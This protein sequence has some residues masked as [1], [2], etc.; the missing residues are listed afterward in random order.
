MHVIDSYF[1]PCL[2]NIDI[3]PTVPCK[4]KIEP[5][6]FL[7]YSANMYSR[8]TMIHTRLWNYM[9]ELFQKEFYF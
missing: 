8:K 4:K 2:G 6:F 1:V 5:L 9:R 3:L 7:D